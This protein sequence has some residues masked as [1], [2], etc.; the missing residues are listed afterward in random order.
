MMP[1]V[2]LLEIVFRNKISDRITA[3]KTDQPDVDNRR[4]LAWI[5][6]FNQV[7]GCLQFY[8]P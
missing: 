1:D 4:Y 5:H 6:L 7:A 2:L 8:F 3:H